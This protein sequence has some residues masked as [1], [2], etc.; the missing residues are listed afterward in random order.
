MSTAGGKA[1]R[2]H[3]A[4]RGPKPASPSRMCHEVS[5]F[6]MRRHGSALPCVMKCHVLCGWRM[7]HGSS[8]HDAPPI[9]LPSPAARPAPP[10]VRNGGQ[11]QSSGLLSGGIEAAAS[12]P[13]PRVSRA[14]GPPRLAPAR[15]ARLI[16]RARR[17]THLSRGFRADFSRAAEKRLRMPLPSRTAYHTFSSVKQFSEQKDGYFRNFS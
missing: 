6:V 14:G 2:I 3:V 10:P 4:G 9:G 8:G 5:C 15:F 17:R 1:H 16:A 7:S 12:S 13:F 11:L